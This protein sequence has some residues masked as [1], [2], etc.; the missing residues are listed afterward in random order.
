[1]LRART[2]TIKDVAKA[3]GVSTATVSRVLNESG[4]V[5][6][7]IKERVFATVT[8]LNYHPNAVAR[9][10]KQDKTFSIGI[11]IPD[12][13]NSYFMAISKGIE[14][15]IRQD[16]YDLIF[17]STEENPA[18]EKKLLGLMLE[19]RVD[20]I[21]LATSG[22]NEEN[23]RKIR[24]MGVPVI[25]VDRRIDD[26]DMGLDFVAEDNVQG[27]YQLTK[28]LLNAGHTR[29]GLVN[30]SLQ[31]STGKDRYEG[32]IKALAEFGIAEDAQLNFMGA[33]TQGG[34]EKA[35][36]WFFNLREKP[37][38]ILA[39][40][41]SM[42]FGVLLELTRRNFR[43]PEDVV[44]AS[45]GEVE[46]AEL[47]KTSGFI[48]LRQCPSQMGVKVGEVLLRRL[49]NPEEKL[50]QKMFVPII[51]TGKYGRTVPQ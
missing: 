26:A 18:K 47:L 8:S 50:F 37:T 46:A 30:G 25:L 2:I 36:E 16:G 14:D 11:V 38:A 44:V 7:G 19:K 4:F 28:Y 17:C 35:V 20:A 1:M 5:S 45:Y 10:L 23:V 29:I 40:N 49:K 42:A 32:Y 3:S 41:N 6:D 39:L 27:A 15:T 48:Y 13:S 9:S 43:I 22:D 31:V 33:F 21:I 24:Q 12:I 34:G 51:S